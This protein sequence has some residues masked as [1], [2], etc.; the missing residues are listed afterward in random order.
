MEGEKKLAG[1][2]GEMAD[3]RS[4]G[5]KSQQVR[6]QA[7][8]T[9]RRVDD[10]TPTPPDQDD[11]RW[12]QCRLPAL[13]PRDCLIVKSPIS[14]WS[15]AHSICWCRTAHT[16]PRPPSGAVCLPSPAPVFF[17]RAPRRIA[18]HDGL[19]LRGPAWKEGSPSTR[20]PGMPRPDGRP[21]L[22]A[23]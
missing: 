12:S 15:Y 23:E 5:C 21:T 8:E 20:Q 4:G 18:H 3:I 16:L 9:S 14:R 19:N 1:W 2:Q 10:G 13:G 17:P 11:K 6:Q 7:S 22:M